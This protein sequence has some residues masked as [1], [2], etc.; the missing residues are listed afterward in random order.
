MSH[1]SVRQPLFAIVLRK[2][3]NSSSLLVHVVLFQKRTYSR[4]GV[5]FNGHNCLP[6]AAMADAY[7]QH[8]EGLRKEEY[9]MLKSRYAQLDYSR[10]KADAGL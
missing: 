5:A 10:L 7:N 1:S 6:P 2:Y 4:T 9:P 8:V 3:E